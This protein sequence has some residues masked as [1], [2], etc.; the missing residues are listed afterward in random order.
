MPK[1][2]VIVPVYKVEK[3]IHRCVDSILTQTFTDFELILV[4]DGSPDNCGAA[5]DSYSL[6]DSRV[7]VIHKQNGGLSDARN[8]GMDIAQGEFIC[9]IDSDDYVHRDFCAVLYE[10]MKDRDVLFST[11]EGLNFKEYDEAEKL[12]DAGNE[13]KKRTYL[14]Y[15]QEGL[16]SR[17]FSACAKLFRREAIGQLRFEKG[18]IHED[19]FFSSELL[20]FR[21]R[22]VVTNSCK[23]YF[24]L[25]RADG[26]MNT[27]KVCSP[28]F[29]EAGMHV[30]QCVNRYCPQLL[31]LGVKYAVSY[32][33]SFVDAI[34][35]RRT[36]CEN[37]KLLRLLRSALQER[38]VYQNLTAF[39]PIMRRRMKLFAHSGFLFGVNAFS[40]LVR[41]Y[42]CRLLGKDPYKTGHGI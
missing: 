33:W 36:F 9:F 24:R 2:S 5:C 29:I 12:C 11:C 23:L 37:K 28:D 4:D 34:Y 40:R 16:A 10:G 27:Q 8:A 14:D 30:V 7:R 31:P 21:D 3:Y 6:Q 32:P 41:V 35:V 13:V 38:I 39:S 18:K 26:I 15:F 42:C 19:V 1:I 17:G 22:S 25:L 20:K